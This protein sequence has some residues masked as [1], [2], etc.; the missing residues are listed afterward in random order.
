[1]IK[2]TREP[3]T[4]ETA[5]RSAIMRAV[6]AR[7]TGPEIALR[8][9]LFARGLRYRLHAARLPGKPDIVF[10]GRRAV[11]FVHGC[12]WHG[13]DCPRGAR[14]PKTNTDYWLAKIARNR[15]RDDRRLNE[16][17][18]LGWRVRVVWE[19]EIKNVDAA[20]DACASWLRGEN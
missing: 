10:P 3:S 16:L 9:A 6:R 4:S 17:A 2:R 7:D 19:C 20:A 8:R 13:H 11:V 12:F 15:A 14:T 1:M 18:G 5:Q